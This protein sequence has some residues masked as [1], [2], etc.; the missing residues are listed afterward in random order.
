M[1]YKFS[2]RDLILHSPAALLLVWKA[3]DENPRGRGTN[4][5][6]GMK[7]KS[8]GAGFTS[9]ILQKKFSRSAFTLLE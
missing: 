8:A 4:E 9:A 7:R 5:R 6:S 1:N 3:T 2:A